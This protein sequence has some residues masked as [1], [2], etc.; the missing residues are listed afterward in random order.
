[1]LAKNWITC[2]GTP[3]AILQGLRS[4]DPGGTVLFFPPSE[5]TAKVEIPLNAVWREEVTMTSSYGGSPRDIQE[6]IEL[7][8]TRQ[9]TVADLITHLLPLAEAGKGFRLVAQAEDSL[10]VV[11]RP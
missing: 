2:T 6:A 4:L 3:K 5:P 9:V 1:P 11:L 7:L 8:A 10:K